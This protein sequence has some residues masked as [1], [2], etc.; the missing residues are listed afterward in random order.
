MSSI[1]ELRNE[2]LGRGTR[3]GTVVKV[4]EGTIQVATDFGVQNYSNPGN[5]SVGDSVTIVDN[6]RVLN[7]NSAE[8]Q[9][10]QG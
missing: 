4:L 2:I 9:V 5:V 7:S 3:R 6:S 1:S 10:F 8:P